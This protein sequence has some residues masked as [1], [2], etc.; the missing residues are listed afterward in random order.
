MFFSSKKPSF[1]LTALLAVLLLLVGCTSQTSSD[2]ADSSDPTENP[3][4][5]AAVGTPVE[6]A[7]V[8]RSDLASQAR[9]SGKV[10]ATRD[11][12]IM[13]P[14]TAKVTAVYVSVGDQVQSGQVLFSLDKSDLQSSYNSLADN[15]ARSKKL[16]EAQIEQAKINYDNTAA[17]LE[18]GAASQMELDAARIALLSAETTASTTLRQLE[19]NMKT[20]R[21]TLADADV[22]STISGRVSSLSAVAGSWASPTTPAAIVSEGGS[23]VTVSVSETVQPYLIPGDT[24]TVYISSLSDDPFLA[25]IRTVSPSAGAMTQLFDVVLDLPSSVTATAGMF[26]T[27]IFETE[28]R[29]N[30]I[31]IP[32]EAILN[33]GISQSVFVVED[34]KAYR[35]IV[36]TGLIGDGVVEVTEGLSGGEQLVVVGQSYLSEGAA[37]RIMEG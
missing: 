29:E 34:G 7:T 24:A 33:D 5:A 26:A 20:L 19:D 17:L 25:T 15:Y 36:T 12:A 22:K 23:Q 11:V 32:N 2:P 6:V 8:A 35:R 13:A 14:L 4:T 1:R 30:A 18:I 3:E 9:L 37:V 21:D 31:V 16:M 10:A 28:R 27:V